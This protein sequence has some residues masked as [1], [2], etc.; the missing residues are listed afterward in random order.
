MSCV[1]RI[2]YNLWSIDQILTHLSHP[3]NTLI[4]V[5]SCTG[6]KEHRTH[7]LEQQCSVL[8]SR[9]K[10]RTEH[11]NNFGPRT[12]NRTEHGN[13]FQARTRTEPEHWMKIMYEFMFVSTVSKRFMSS[14]GQVQSGRSW[15][16]VDGPW[17]DETGQSKGMTVDGPNGKSGLCEG[18][19]LGLKE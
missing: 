14:S 16:K 9:T 12:Q 5:H 11:K 15:V 4:H 19:K 17:G 10:N 6:M 3:S 1:T 2:D 8:C 18:I 7:V 13:F